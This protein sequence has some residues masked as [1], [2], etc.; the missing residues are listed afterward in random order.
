M[1]ILEDENDYILKVLCR[2]EYLMLATDIEDDFHLGDKVNIEG[3]YQITKIDPEI[4]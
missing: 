2:P 4:D 1:E 3:D